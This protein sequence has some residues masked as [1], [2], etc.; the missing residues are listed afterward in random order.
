MICSTYDVMNLSCLVAS[1]KQEINLSADVW[2]LGC[3]PIS[4]GIRY[5]QGNAVKQ[6]QGYLQARPWHTAQHKAAEKEDKLKAKIN[7][8]LQKPRAAGQN[9]QTTLL[10]FFRP[11][12]TGM[13]LAVVTSLTLAVLFR[14]GSVAVLRNSLQLEEI[15]MSEC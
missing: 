15:P 13:M 11:G 12:V 9:K 3:G 8:E 7:S 10:A 1:H 14:R 4:R 5:I 2:A 6:T